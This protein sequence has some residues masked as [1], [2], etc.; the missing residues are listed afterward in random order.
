MCATTSAVRIWIYGAC[1][2]VYMSVRIC[3]YMY[4]AFGLALATFGTA[5]PNSR[6]LSL[7][8]FRS[9]RAT[10]GPCFFAPLFPLSS[11]PSSS[12]FASVRSVESLPSFLSS[13]WLWPFPSSIYFVL[14][15]FLPPLS[16]ARARRFSLRFFSSSCLVYAIFFFFLRFLRFVVL[17][18]LW[19][20][21]FVV[22]FCILGSTGLTL[23]LTDEDPEIRE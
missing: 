3:V 10:L 7:A 6:S 23:G 4:I 12:F 17:F 5:V 16:L 21:F 13:L 11:S 8:L 20:F 19:I 9:R 2:C 18:L 14:C 1:V 22:L 15:S